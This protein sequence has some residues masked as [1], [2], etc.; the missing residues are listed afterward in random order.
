MRTTLLFLLPAIAACGSTWTPVDL[1]GDGISAAEGDC[2]D[3]VEGPEGSGLGGDAIRPGADETWYDGV[4][5]DCDGGSDYDADADGYDSLAYGNGVD[6]DDEDAAVFPDASEI[7]DGVDNDCDGAA[8]MDDDDLE[9]LYWYTDADGDDYGDPDTEVA[10]CDAPTGTVADGTDCDDSEGDVYPGAPERCDSTDQDC[11]GETRD[12]DST[13]ASTWYADDDGDGFDADALAACE[14]VADIDLGSDYTARRYG[15]ATSMLVGSSV[16]EAGD[17]DGDGVGDV[18][19]GA[20]G[21]SSSAGRAFLY[22][23]PI[24]AISDSVSGD[25]QAWFTGEDTDDELGASLAS[26][27]DLDGDGYDDVLIGAPG[28]ST[29]AGRGYLLLGPL[30]GALTVTSLADGTFSGPADGDRAGDR[31]SGVGDLTGDGV[32]EF[33]IAAPATD[34]ST[35]A[36][37]GVVYL[38]AGGDGESDLTLSTSDA[39]VSFVGEARDDEAGGHLDG[40]GDFDGDGVPDIAIG[41]PKEDSGGTTA[42][43]AYLILDADGLSG[44]VELSAADAKLT[45][46]LDYDKAS[47]VAFAGDL[48]GDGRDDLVVVAPGVDDAAGAAG[49]VYILYGE[50]SPSSGSLSAADLQLDGVSATESAGESVDG[51]GDVNGD[52]D[53]DLIV[54]APD[55]ETD[56]SAPGQ[57]YLVYGPFGTG[58]VSLSTADVQIAGGAAGDHAGVAVAGLGDANGNGLGDVGIGA[59]YY[60]SSTKTDVGALY[61][62]SGGY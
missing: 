61:L 58:T 24:S 9:P 6:C 13:D 36:G 11:D 22:S 51:A 35:L 54:G 30:A 59:P 27:G 49:A 23:G 29:E 41:A 56:L 46:A 3:A 12:D 10:A 28:N 52:G 38:L 47:R 57:A 17:V 60:D 2:W 45:G 55:T 43:A 14:L 44:V 8:D 4:D 34:Y 37:K 53:L 5:Q 33:L 21:Y 42:G 7:C 19:V 1:D 26:A 15:S 50:T 18:L 62:L 25:Y 20:P 32:A 48:D 40:G 39:L 31:V 16:A